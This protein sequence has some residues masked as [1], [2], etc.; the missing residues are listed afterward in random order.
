MKTN[1]YTLSQTPV[2]IHPDKDGPE[3]IYIYPGGNDVYVGDATVTSNT[4][5]PLIKN[6][7]NAIF[8]RGHQTL[9]AI[10]ATGSHT[11]IVL[12]ESVA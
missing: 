2:I 10:C 4:G 7:P 11:L 1:V 5:L 12:H 9:Y 8:L 3:T 6:N